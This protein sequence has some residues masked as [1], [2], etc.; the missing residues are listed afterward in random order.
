MFVCAESTILMN[1]PSLPVLTALLLVALAG[2]TATA[3]AQ[4]DDKA[5]Q[6]SASISPTVDFRS[7]RWLSDRDIINDNAEVI[8]SVSDLILDRGSGRIEYAIIKTSGN[9]GTSGKLVT[10]PYTSLRWEAGDKDRFVLAATTEQLTLFPEYTAERWNAM[11]DGSKKD[12]NGL[13]DRLEADNKSS[14]DPYAG[15]LENSVNTRIEGE[16]TGV[17]RVR[18]TTFGEQ[19]EVSI[20]TTDGSTKRVA[21]GPSWFVSATNAAP[22]RGD[23][24]VV[25]AMSLPRDPEQLLA[26]SNYRSGNRELRLRDASGS[27]TWALKTIESNGQSYSAPYSRY[28][29]ISKIT[30]LKVDCRGDDCGKVND[31]ILDRHSGQIAFLSIDPNQ[32]F[33]GISDTKRLLPWSIATVTLDDIVRIDASKDMVLQ[34]PETPADITTLSNGTHAE[35]VYKA[36]NVPAP[37]FDPAEKRVDNRMSDPSNA[38]GHDGAVNGAIERSAVTSMQGSVLDITDVKFDNGTAPARAIKVR[39]LDKSQGD[40]LVLLGPVTYMN[41]QKTMCKVGDSIKLDAYRTT[42]DNRQYWLA[43]SVDCNSTRV[44]LVDG[45]NAPAWAQR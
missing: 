24:V 17:E 25:D 15:S 8:A 1:R 33:L 37:R 38:W 43:R 7:A 20:K 31:V 3:I 40:Y 6:T 5:H 29:P 4:S 41:N 39:S 36:F 12:E 19:V 45:N 35:R 28:L 26:A 27:P 44:V 14:G 34:S 2:S 16:I 11:R 21:I 22:M 13:R 42:I 30:G 18:T 23:K 10:V 32:N 9:Y